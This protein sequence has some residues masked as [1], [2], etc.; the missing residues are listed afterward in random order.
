VAGDGI[1]TE[2]AFANPL[3]VTLVW[4][5]IE[6]FCPATSAAWLAKCFRLP[7]E[8]ASRV[9]WRIGAEGDLPR[10]PGRLEVPIILL[11][12]LFRKRGPRK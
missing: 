9:R 2:E 11:A 7:R 3:N 1:E 12:L 5:D 6:G 4:Y 10:A 8:S